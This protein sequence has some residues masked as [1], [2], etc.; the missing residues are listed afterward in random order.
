VANTLTLNPTISRSPNPR[1]VSDDLDIYYV[2]IRHGYGIQTLQP[3]RPITS[4]QHQLHYLPSTINQNPGLSLHPEH[5]TV[6]SRPI[7]ANTWPSSITSKAWPTDSREKWT[8]MGLD[9]T[10]WKLPMK[11][12]EGICQGIYAKV[13]IRSRQKRP[14]R[15]SQQRQVH[16][17]TVLHLF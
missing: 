11:F 6:S 7:P 3:H 15:P 12:D 17:E 16:A 9:T 10:N 14:E 13:K 5:P 2:G 4:L 8:D 1:A